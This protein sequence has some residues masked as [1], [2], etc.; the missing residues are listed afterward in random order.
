MRKFIGS[1]FTQGSPGPNASCIRSSL[2]NHLLTPVL[3]SHSSYEPQ[4]EQGNR[5]KELVEV[6]RRH[7]FKYG[8][9][10]LQ[11]D[12]LQ[13]VDWPSSGSFPIRSNATDTD[14]REGQICCSES[15]A[16]ELSD[17]LRDWFQGL[18]PMELYHSTNS[19][20][21]FGEA[22]G[23]RIPR[24]VS[25][26]L[27]DMTAVA[28]QSRWLLDSFEPVTSNGDRNPGFQSSSC[29][30]HGLAHFVSRVRACSR[31]QIESPVFYSPLKHAATARGEGDRD[32]I[33][34]T[35]SPE[36]QAEREK[37]QR[38]KQDEFNRMAL[39]AKVLRMETGSVDVAEIG[40]GRGHL[41]R[42]MEL[43]GL[44]NAVGLDG[45]ERLVESTPSS[46]RGSASRRR[47]GR[48]KVEAVL[49]S[50]PRWKGGFAVDASRSL[51]LCSPLVLGL[52]T[53]G[54]LADE[55]LRFG[56]DRG[57][58]A[59]INVPC[60]YHKLRPPQSWGSGEHGHLVGPQPSSNST[61]SGLSTPVGLQLAGRAR[62]PMTISPMDYVKWYWYSFFRCSLR[63]MIECHSSMVGVRNPST[64]KDG[65]SSLDAL[66]RNSQL[67]THPECWKV[68][69]PSTG[70]GA[71]NRSSP[72]QLLLWSCFTEEPLTPETIG[73][74][75]VE[76]CKNWQETCAQSFSQ[77]QRGCSTQGS[78]KLICSDQT[79]VDF[80]MHPDNF[81]RAQEQVSFRW[82]A[83]W[84]AASV[85]VVIMGARVQ[86]LEEN[87]YDA[88]VGPLLSPITSSRFLGVVAVRRGLLSTPLLQP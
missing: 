24:R 62:N 44:P 66:F 67:E 52:H 53:C 32:V 80:L 61:L 77:G 60:C 70:K 78:P 73:S 15:E 58:P 39:L 7:L 84:I 8:P 20:K 83:Q 49:Q 42:A 14:D 88:V 16:A 63:R 87:G 30:R 10:F 47:T 5:F 12:S 31:F 11:S 51:H 21:P 29:G 64:Q 57:S 68:A 76:Y 59:I 23:A 71:P 45:D 13:W 79:L 82:I 41:L 37:Y 69:S 43:L 19:L 6:H 40:C 46:S 27:S 3:R 81:C 48:D 18:S 4:P 65:S 25:L 38:R 9:F 55:C 86:S 28:S 1:S 17:A 54:H 74:A 2:R 33:K 75:F 36:A 22:E 26:L 34:A 85:E 72:I 35:S 56:V 50:F